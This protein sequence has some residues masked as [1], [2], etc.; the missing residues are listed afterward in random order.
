MRYINPKLPNILSAMDSYASFVETQHGCHASHQEKIHC[1]WIAQLRGEITQYIA[2]IE[3]KGDDGR[4]KIDLAA[5]ITANSI[6][7][8]LKPMISGIQ[9]TMTEFLALDPH[10][11]NRA[12]SVLSVLSE[13]YERFQKSI[14][15]AEGLEPDFGCPQHGLPMVCDLFRRIREIGKG[16]EEMLDEH[17]GKTPKHVKEEIRNVLEDPEDEL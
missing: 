1:T 11:A 9:S 7:A 13:K 14:K 8:E 12:L 10:N 6:A 2:R 3:G 17:L 4:N 15:R 5:L 16:V